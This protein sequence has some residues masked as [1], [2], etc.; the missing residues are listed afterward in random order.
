MIPDPSAL[1]EVTFGPIQEDQ[2]ADWRAEQASDDGDDDDIPPDILAAI[3]G[4]DPRTVD[5]E[6]ND[7]E[8]PK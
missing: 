7:I 6:G 1:P 5:D 8:V 3:L 2:P 4:F